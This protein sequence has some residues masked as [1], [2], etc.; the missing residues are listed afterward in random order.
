MTNMGQAL[1][2]TLGTKQSPN[3]AK[4]PAFVGLMFKRE[5][6]EEKYISD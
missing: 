2:W 6:T 5:R 1:S 3:Q 4:I